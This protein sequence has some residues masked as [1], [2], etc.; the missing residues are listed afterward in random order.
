MFPDII[1]TESEVSRGTLYAYKL[2]AERILKDQEEARKRNERA[3]I[4]RPWTYD[5]F[6]QTIFDRGETLGNQF[7]FE[8]TIPEHWDEVLHLLALYFTNDPQF[9]EEGLN[10]V[11]YSLKKGIWLQSAGRGVGKTVLMNLCAQNKRQCFS[12][13]SMHHI[14]LRFQ[15]GSGINEVEKLAKLHQVEP[16]RRNYYQS[17]AG[18]MYD[19]FFGE[20]PVNH[21][22]N[23]CDLSAFIVNSLYD[24]NR[25]HGQFWKFHVT[26][27]FSGQEIEDKSG[28]TIRSRMVEMFNLIKMDGPDLRHKTK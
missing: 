10:G 20:E 26:S 15:K 23:K 28:A 21:M 12:S 14:R 7:G 24:I 3:E 1:P 27:N 13:M 8:F 25:Y 19:E 11:K 6:K 5:E 18:F 4:M 16:G 17:E 2:A 9:E 22:G